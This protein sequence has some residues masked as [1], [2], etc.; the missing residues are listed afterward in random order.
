MPGLNHTGPAGQGPMTGRRMG[1]CTR[2][3]TNE[4][5]MNA[6][7]PTTEGTPAENEHITPGCGRG[8]SWGRGRGFSCR[9]GQS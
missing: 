1:R 5:A 3:G 7:L 2:F 9:N 4:K 6:E 8:R